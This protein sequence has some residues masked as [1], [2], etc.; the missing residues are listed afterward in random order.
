MSSRRDQ[1]YDRPRGTM[2]GTKCC[3]QGKIAGLYDLEGTLGKG[4]F[5]VVKLARHVFTGEKVAVKVIDKSKL[6]QAA[7]GHLLQEV[8]CMKLVQHPNV[9][10]LY[11]VIDTQTKL[12]LILELGDGGD[13][14]DHIMKY[15]GGLSEPQAKRYF[16]QIVH[17]ISYCHKLHVVHRDLKPENVVFFKEQGVVKLTDF[18]FSNRFQPGT[19]LTTSCGSLAYSAPEILLG[20]EYDAPAVDIWSLGVILYMLVCGHP[21]FQ[22]VNDSETLT[23][24]MDCRYTIPEHM[25][26]QCADLISRMLQRVPEQRASLEEIEAHPWLQGVDPSPA[27]RSPLPLTSYKSVSEEEHE[28]IIQAMMCGNIA[29]RG[30]IQE[31]LEFD[32]Y[33]HITATYFLLAERILREKQNQPL[34]MVYSW[35]T[36]DQNRRP[37]SQPIGPSGSNEGHSAFADI[38]DGF[39][40]FAT[41][42]SSS[43]TFAED[44]GMSASC[45]R[46]FISLPL[47]GEEEV[48]PYLTDHGQTVR[49]LLRPSLLDAPI[50]RSLPALQQIY[51]EEEEEDGEESPNNLV[52]QGFLPKEE[53]HMGSQKSVLSRSTSP[54]VSV[55]APAHESSSNSNGEPGLLEH[56]LGTSIHLSDGDLKRQELKCDSLKQTIHNITNKEVVITHNSSDL[57]LGVNLDPMGHQELCCRKERHCGAQTENERP[58]LTYCDIEDILEAEDNNNT[59]KLEGTNVEQYPKSMRQLHPLNSEPLVIDSQDYPFTQGAESL[60]PNFPAVPSVLEEKSRSSKSASETRSFSRPKHSAD[61]I[62]ESSETATM[63]IESPADPVI[64]LDPAKNKSSNLKDRILQFPLCEKA[65]AFRI[66]PNSKESLLSLGQF[67][68]CHVI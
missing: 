59:T 50:A 63:G 35:T 41:H 32:R 58:T 47:V 52:D 30:A 61:K 54:N 17:A 6:D 22:E 65:L 2:A 13:M 56:L 51:E 42:R 12:Y 4:H 38:T 27:S 57:I 67:N 53:E 11:E 62:S 33:N 28:V 21:P 60:K 39:S 31:A 43:E 29:D 5:A 64:K 14:F 37:L 3:Y 26:S 48:S 16:A 10:R 68:C 55:H 18:G 8:L 36:T 1:S 23:M 19:M 44:P 45:K 20:D 49:M 15:E 7:A 46:K 9:V 40:A 24:I 25:S 34:N 66:K